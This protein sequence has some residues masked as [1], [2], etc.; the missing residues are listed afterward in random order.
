M[1]TFETHVR[2]AISQ[3]MDRSLSWHLTSP[4]PFCSQGTRSARVG[5]IT[6]SRMPPEARASEQ[7]FLTNR[8]SIAAVVASTNGNEGQEGGHRHTANTRKEG[9]NNAD[10]EQLD[11]LRLPKQGEVTAREMCSSHEP[12]NLEWRGLL[13]M[14]RCKHASP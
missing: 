14:S 2:T 6:K 4:G 11:S 9:T 8:K 13:A 5:D 10:H 12:V 1:P 7:T 3:P